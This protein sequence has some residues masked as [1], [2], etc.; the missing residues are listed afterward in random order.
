MNAVGSWARWLVTAVL[1]IAAPV[2]EA[3]LVGDFGQFLNPSGVRTFPDPLG[4]VLAHLG[5]RSIEFPISSTT[6][7]FAYEYDSHRHTFEQSVTSLGPVFAERAETVGDGRF[8]VGFTYAY[9]NF[10]EFDGSDFTTES[11]VSCC[12]NEVGATLFTS[13]DISIPIHQFAFSGTYGI[14]ERWDVND[15]KHRGG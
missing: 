10:D 2:C 1:V 14:T 13:A 9:G 6:P 12:G 11:S 8:S 15:P 4:P 5:A 7:G 3:S